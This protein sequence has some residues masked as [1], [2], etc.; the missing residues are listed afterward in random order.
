MNYTMA[1]F[2]IQINTKPLYFVNSFLILKFLQ[3]L[4]CIYDV[5]KKLDIMGVENKTGF[6]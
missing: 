4:L 6:V 3:K 2:V 1:A 5:L